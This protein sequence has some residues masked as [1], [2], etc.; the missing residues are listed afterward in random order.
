M[1]AD[2]C[3]LEDAIILATRA[4][5]GALD[6]GGQPYILH[7]LRVM[8]GVDEPEQKQIAV[9]HDVVEDSHLTIAVLRLL[10]FSERV[11]AGVDAMTRRKTE[12]YRQYIDR[13]CQNKD[14]TLVK[15][16]DIDDNSNFSRLPQDQWGWL[17]NMIEERWGPAEKRLTDALFNTTKETQ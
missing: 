3:T 5:R 8:L 12:T 10:G 4:H 9:L 1:S 16:E 2:P 14:A 7:P 17:E 13:V 11:I 15:L 6:K